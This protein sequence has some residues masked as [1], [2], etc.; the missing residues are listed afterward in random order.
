VQSFLFKE[1]T[2]ATG[3]FRGLLVTQNFSAIISFFKFHRMDCDTSTSFLSILKDIIAPVLTPLL[4]YWAGLHTPYAINKRRFRT[5]ARNLNVGVRSEEPREWN[6]EIINGSS[7]PMNDVHAYISINHKYEDVASALAPRI[8]N[9]DESRRQVNSD[10][11]FWNHHLPERAEAINIHPQEAKNLYFAYFRDEQLSTRSPEYIDD[12]LVLRTLT[13]GFSFSGETSLVELRRHRDYVGILK[14]VSADSIAS[15][16][17]L[18]IKATIMSNPIAV[19]KI[20]KAQAEK[21]QREFNQIWDL[22]RP[23]IDAANHSDLI[24]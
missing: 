7:Y 2:G 19:A 18:N 23:L 16:F 1:T 20:T 6:L 3:K 24:T 17:Q 8:I 13:I 5:I 4:A 22:S 11:L 14:I 10:I 15:F 12:D 9:D 21:L